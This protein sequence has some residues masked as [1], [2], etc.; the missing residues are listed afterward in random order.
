M[1]MATERLKVL[2]QRNINLLKRRAAFAIKQYRG[3]S[4]RSDCGHQVLQ[5]ISPEAAAL[6]ASFDDAMA[7]LKKLDP[8]CPEYMPL[9]SPR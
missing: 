7:E 1:P 5:Y 4:N 9:S 8:T 3:L 2:R 6:A